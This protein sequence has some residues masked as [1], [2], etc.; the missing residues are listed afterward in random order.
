MSGQAR[1]QIVIDATNDAGGELSA[2]KKDLAGVGDGAGKAAL[3]LRDFGGSVEEAINAQLKQEAATK[4]MEEARSE[5]SKMSEEEK[6]ARLAADEL[7]E[8]QKKAGEEADKSSKGF[9]IAGLS[10]TDMASGIALAKQGI[11]VLK[12]VWDFAKAGAENDRIAASFNAAA[13]SIGL[14]ADLLAAALDKAAKGTVDDELLMQAATRAMTV[15]VTTDF[16]EIVQLMELAKAASVRFG[17]DAGTAFERITTAISNLQPRGL[18]EY[19]IAADDA[20]TRQELLNIALQQGKKLIDETGKSGLDNKDKIARFEKQV[21]DLG[22]AAKAAAIEGLAPLLDRATAV[23]VLANKSATTQEQLAAAYVLARGAIGGSGGTYDDLI[24][25]LEESIRLQELLGLTTEEK[26][27]RAAMKHIRALEEFDP[28]AGAAADQLLDMADASDVS[29]AALDRLTKASGKLADEG[30]SMLK[31][32]LAGAVSNEME[33]FNQKQDELK[34]KAGELQDKISTSYGKVKTDA[35]KELGEVNTALESNAAKHEEATRRILFGYAEQAL[36]V[37]GLTLTE[38]AALDKLALT[39][40]LKSQEDIDAMKRIQEA[41][42]NLA[43]DGNIDAFADKVSGGM[44]SVRTDVGLASESAKELKADFDKLQSKTIRIKTI[45][46]QIGENPF[47]AQQGPP[48]P[49]R[50]SGGPTGAGGLYMLH[51]DEWV[52]SSAQRRGRESIPAAAI[53]AAS[54][55][56]AGVR[57]VTYNLFDTL[58]ARI[59][60]ERE[61]QEELRVIESMM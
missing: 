49:S 16:E 54:A 36:S 9:K 39:W 2:V 15:G 43:S 24:R 17:G 11:D 30:L 33:S 1:L 53:P 5:I 31:L 34:A 29:G 45:Y 25:R 37:D 18:K 61:R 60:A 23:E 6:V 55:A 12:Q 13:T 47:P 10:L 19:G 57:N 22:D 59:V 35:Q 4:V 51:P 48:I 50:A 56:G 20:R 21:G 40:N 7:A 32:S 3:S 44:T 58:T 14:D 28:V 41:A 46:E 8:S 42:L 38:I 52:L 27:V 26:A